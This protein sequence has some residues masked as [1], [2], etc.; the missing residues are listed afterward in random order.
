MQKVKWPGDW[1]VVCDVCGFQY[2]RSQIQ[3]RW[4]GLQVCAKDYETRHPMDF[5]KIRG[6]SAFPDVV[7]PEPET[8]TFVSVTYPFPLDQPTH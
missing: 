4:D 5:M 3:Q 6:E 1:K 7:R 8:D 2:P